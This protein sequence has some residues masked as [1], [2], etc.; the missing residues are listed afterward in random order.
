MGLIAPN[1]Q[2]KP[3]GVRCVGV[4]LILKMS[5]TAIEFTRKTIMKEITSG[6]L[7]WETYPNN[8]VRLTQC[9]QDCNQL[10]HFYEIVD[11]DSHLYECHMGYKLKQFEIDGQLTPIGGGFYTATLNKPVLGKLV[12]VTSMSVDRNSIAS[13]NV[14]G[15]T[16]V[17]KS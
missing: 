4:I 1:V 6:M 3:K 8:S 16:T 15:F 11:F 14:L 10:R 9:Y 2:K 17:T 12:A 7:L 13:D 5:E